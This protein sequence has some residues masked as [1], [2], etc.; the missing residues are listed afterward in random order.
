[1][2]KGDQAFATSID[3]E[4]VSVC[5]MSI[6]EEACGASVVLESMPDGGVEAV[7]P[8]DIKCLVVRRFFRN[9]QQPGE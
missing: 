8:G 2:P 6:G 7:T 3:R 1:M 9:K 5:P 4:I